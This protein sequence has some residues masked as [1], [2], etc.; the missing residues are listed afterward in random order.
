MSF[1]ANSFR[2]GFGLLALALAAASAVVCAQSAAAADDNG[3][4]EITAES[5]AAVERG[6]RWLAANQGREGNWESNDLG[7]VAVGGLAFLSA[8]HL[9]GIGEHGA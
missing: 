6:L 9:P 8:G 3:D 1:S 5:E 7:L 2:Y 4:W